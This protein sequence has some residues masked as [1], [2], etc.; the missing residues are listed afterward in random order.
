[1]LEHGVLTKR[2]IGLAIEVHKVAGPGLLESAYRDF[3]Y[4]E[5][6]DAGIPFQ[7]EVAVPVIY[8]GRQGRLGYRA[9]NLVADAILEIKGV[10]SLI[11][12]HDAQ[13][14]TCLRMS[15]FRTGLLMNFHVRPLKDGLRR[16]II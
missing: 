10:A 3:M 5:L 2:V 16:V 7:R 9:D 8:K 12:A 11:P 15:Q 6:E 1:M 13:I 14:L 4:I